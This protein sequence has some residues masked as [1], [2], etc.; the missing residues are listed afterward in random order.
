MREWTIDAGR[1]AAAYELSKASE[2]RRRPGRP[3]EYVFDGSFTMRLT[4][5]DDR[6]GTVVGE[7]RV[8][9]DGWYN[10]FG[11]PTD[12]AAP[13]LFT[14]KGT[15][16]DHLSYGGIGKGRHTIEYRAIDAAGNVGEPRKF[17]ATLR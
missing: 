15:V 14:D 1:P 8:D 2:V 12:S 16:I 10:Y 4:T 5:S 7:F 17:I 9:G 6:P 13:F 3:P 11:W